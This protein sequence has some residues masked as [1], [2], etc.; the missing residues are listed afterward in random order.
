MT[1]PVRAEAQLSPASRRAAYEH[2]YPLE[3]PPGRACPRCGAP[4]QLLAAEQRTPAG[5]PRHTVALANCP[6]H[7]THHGWTWND[8]G[9][10]NAR[11]FNR[12]IPTDE[13]DDPLPSCRCDACRG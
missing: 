11:A 5:I 13:L 12:W 10:P 6:E 7:G 2:P 3:D 1:S 9:S 8:D 4:M